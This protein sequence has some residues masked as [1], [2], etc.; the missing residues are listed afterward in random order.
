M[1]VLA[2]V[3]KLGDAKL[4]KSSNQYHQIP[5]KCFNRFAAIFI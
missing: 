4:K 5:A 3:F 1:R 2:G